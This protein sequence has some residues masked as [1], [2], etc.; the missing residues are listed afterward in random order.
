MV[1]GGGYRQEGIGRRVSGA[2][3][4]EEHLGMAQEVIIDLG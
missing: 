3:Y 2:D 1:S 4:R